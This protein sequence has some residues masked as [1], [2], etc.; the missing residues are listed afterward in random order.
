M[1]AIAGFGRSMQFPAMALLALSGAACTLIR[2]TSS[3]A[4]YTTELNLDFWRP[5]PESAGRSC[6]ELVR[7][8]GE[9]G[10][11]SEDATRRHAHWNVRSRL[12]LL[13]GGKARKL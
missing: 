1:R 11:N 10:R 7:S 5:L 6:V 2:M 13:H 8:P 3:P 9:S 12:I 4:H